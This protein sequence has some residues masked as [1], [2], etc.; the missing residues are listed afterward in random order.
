MQSQNG[1]NV[2]C[3]YFLGEVDKHKLIAAVSTA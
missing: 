3:E 2:D 1:A